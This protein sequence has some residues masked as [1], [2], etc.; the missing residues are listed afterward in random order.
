MGSD[1]HAPALTSFEIRGEIGRGSI[2]AVFLAHDPHR[3]REIVIKELAPGLA[4]DPE[5]QERFRAA[6]RKLVA[7]EHP[8]LTETLGFYER[9]GRCALVL[10]QLAGGTLWQRFAVEGFKDRAAVALALEVG[11]GLAAAHEAGLVHGGVKPENV[12]FDSRGRA[13]LTDLGMRTI[14]AGCVPLTETAW[15]ALPYAAP[16]QIS[17]GQASA[18]S[19]VHG[20]A[21]M[22]YELLTGE[23][24]RQHA[25]EPLTMLY[26]AANEPPRPIRSVAPAVPEPLAEAIDAAL[27]PDP[28]SRPSAHDF[29]DALA[30]AADWA[31]GDSWRGG[32]G[33]LSKPIGTP[34][35]RTAPRG[36]IW[37]SPVVTSTR[38]RPRRVVGVG[39][40]ALVACAAGLAIG[41]TRGHDHP[42][43]TASAAPPLDL[44][45]Q[46][47][48]QRWYS[49]FDKGDLESASLLWAFPATTN[50][51]N[52]REQ[53]LA[54]RADVITTF[55]LAG[56][57]A[58]VLAVRSVEDGVIVTQRLQTRPDGVCPKDIQGDV[59]RIHYTITRG[60]IRGWHFS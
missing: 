33:E 25:D 31:W 35:W 32:R 24:P 44:T 30:R 42:K 43:P 11:D 23:P 18:A 55:S 5:V 37:H 4:A 8:H 20:L 29:V 54:S 51:D 53:D 48:V 38:P 2:G 12:L 56:C 26:R 52:G 15:G 13:K 45:P 1:E 47:V 46:Q 39:V 9:N 3:D 21:A 36:S 59:E 57:G 50:V 17:E 16:E 6:A 22:T 60:R 40:L 19:D 41:L 10:E 14:A 27:T 28:A 58:K 7:L 34:S 49:A